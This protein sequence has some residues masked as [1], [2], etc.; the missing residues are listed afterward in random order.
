MNVKEV[1][2]RLMGK[3]TPIAYRDERGFPIRK[4]TPEE[5]EL[6]SYM[7]ERRRK[8][9]NEQLALERRKRFTEEMTYGG[10]E[11]K[12][13]KVKPLPKVKDKL[14]TKSKKLSK[15]EACIFFK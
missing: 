12:L 1:I 4:A 2:S 9:V 13:P 11:L 15:K 14:L 3:G 10:Q 5:L 7:E 6:E 8:K